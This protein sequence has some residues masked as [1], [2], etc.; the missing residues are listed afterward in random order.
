MLGILF[1]LI[2]LLLFVLAGCGQTLFSQPPAD[3]IA[4][5]LAF[6]VAATLIGPYGPQMT[7]GRPPA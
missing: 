1:R 4:F 7:W 6:W 2:A 5:G 3:L